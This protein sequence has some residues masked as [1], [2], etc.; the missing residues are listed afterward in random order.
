[1]NALTYSLNEAFS[2]IPPDLVTDLRRMLSLDE[3]LRPGALE[4]TGND[5]LLVYYFLFSAVFLT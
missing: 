3:S 5:C 2:V 4:F 1:M